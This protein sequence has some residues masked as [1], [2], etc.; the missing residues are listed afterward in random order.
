MP[1][2]LTTIAAILSSSIPQN[3][4]ILLWLNSLIPLLV[5]G[6]P[7]VT[8]SF[9]V[10]VAA[11]SIGYRVWSGR[12]ANFPFKKIPLRNFKILLLATLVPS[13][14]VLLGKIGVIIWIAVAKYDTN[15][16]NLNLLKWTAIDHPAACLVNDFIYIFLCVLSVC[17]AKPPMKTKTINEAGKKLQGPGLWARNIVMLFLFLL[18]GVWPNIFSL[19]YLTFF[20]I[21]IFVHNI[22][23]NLPRVHG[24]TWSIGTFL[25]VFVT[26]HTAFVLVMLGSPVA[27]TVT[28]NENGALTWGL[29]ENNRRALQILFSF[30]RDQ[31]ITWTRKIFAA[32]VLPGLFWTFL[33]ILYHKPDAETLR[34]NERGIMRDGRLAVYKPKPF[35]FWAS[36]SAIVLVEPSILT[37]P[38]LIAAL[39]SLYQDSTWRKFLWIGVRRPNSFLA[40]QVY[41][42]L[43]ICIQY[44]YN[45]G[46]HAGLWSIPETSGNFNTVMGLFLCTKNSFAVA[47]QLAC[48]MIWSLLLGGFRFDHM[49]WIL[50]CTWVRKLLLAF[51]FVLK[52][53]FILEYNIQLLALCFFGGAIFYPYLKPDKLQT[54]KYIGIVS[55]INFVLIAALMIAKNY[56][57][58]VWMVLHFISNIYVVAAYFIA[59]FDEGTLV[60][61]CDSHFLIT[62]RGDN[63]GDAPSLLDRFGIVF[64]SLT[65]VLICWSEKNLHDEYGEQRATSDKSILFDKLISQIRQPL[66]SPDRLSTQYDKAFS[67]FTRRLELISFTFRRILLLLT[68]ALTCWAVILPPV[69]V[70]SAF[71]LFST[72]FILNSIGIPLR[73]GEAQQKRTRV[74]R[75]TMHIHFFMLLLF[76]LLRF[77]FAMFLYELAY[78]SDVT[79]S[80][81]PSNDTSCV[82]RFATIGVL[83]TSSGYDNTITFKSGRGGF[84]TPSELGIDT[85]DATRFKTLILYVNAVVA[86]WLYRILYY[87]EHTNKQKMQIRSSV[88]DKDPSAS[89]TADDIGLGNALQ[90]ITENARSAS[91]SL[92]NVSRLAD[93]LQ[94]TPSKPSVA[95]EEA[96]L[97]LSTVLQAPHSR[98]ESVVQASVLQESV[99]QESLLHGSLPPDNLPPESLPPESLPPKSVARNDSSPVVTLEEQEQPSVE[100]EEEK[101]GFWSSIEIPM[102]LIEMRNLLVWH[103][104]A[105]L[106]FLIFLISVSIRTDCL[107]MLTL[108][109]AVTWMCIGRWWDK[110]AIVFIF[111]TIF[112]FCAQYVLRF[113]Y[114]DEKIG[115]NSD[116]AGRL[117]WLGVR[118]DP[119]QT[120][121][122]STA[123]FIPIVARN[124]SLVVVCV[125]QRSVQSEFGYDSATGTFMTARI[126]GFWSKWAVDIATGL[127]FFLCLVRLNCQA[128]IYALATVFW[129]PKRKTSPKILLISYA[130]VLWFGLCTQALGI[131]SH[132]LFET[133]GKSG[134]D[135]ALVLPSDWA[136]YVVEAF[137][138]LKGVEWQV[139]ITCRLEWRRWC[140]LPYS[141]KSGEL[142]KDSTETLSAFD[143]GWDFVVLLF[144]ASTLRLFSANAEASP[145]GKRWQRFRLF[146]VTNLPGLMSVTMFLNG[147]HYGLIGFCSLMC[148]FIYLYLSSRSKK[149][150][151]R[152][153]YWIHTFNFVVLLLRVCN[154]C[155]FVPCSSSVEDDQQRTFHYISTMICRDIVTERSEKTSWPGMLLQFL[156]LEKKVA[157]TYGLLFYNTM[158]GLIFFFAIWTTLSVLSLQNSELY[159]KHVEEGHYEL[160]KQMYPIR[161]RRYIEDF[162]TN[163]AL[164][165]E[166]RSNQKRVTMRK[167]RRVLAFVDRLLT[168]NTRAF[169]DDEEQN[170]VEQ[171]ALNQGYEEGA[172]RTVINYLDTRDRAVI[173]ELLQEIRLA[174]AGKVRSVDVFQHAEQLRRDLSDV[175]AS[176][177]ELSDTKNLTAA[178]CVVRGRFWKRC[179]IQKRPYEWIDEDGSDHVIEFRAQRDL[180]LLHTC[181]SSDQH[182]LTCDCVLSNGIKIIKGETLLELANLPLNIG[183]DGSLQLSF[184]LPGGLGIG[185]VVAALL[186]TETPETCTV[187][188]MRTRKVRGGY[189]LTT[190]ELM[191]ARK[192]YVTPDSVF[193]GLKVKIRNR[194]LPVLNHPYKGQTGQ[195]TKYD[196]VTQVCEVS[197][198][199]GFVYPYCIGAIRYDLVARMRS[200]DK[201]EVIEPES[202]EKSRTSMNTGAGFKGKHEAFK[203]ESLEMSRAT[204]KTGGRLDHEVLITPAHVKYC[205]KK[206]FKV[207]RTL[208]CIA[209]DKDVDAN[210]A[211]TLVIDDT[212][213]PGLVGVRW[214]SK[215]KANQCYRVG[216]PET[217]LKFSFDLLPE[218]VIA[219]DDVDEFVACS[220][221]PSL[222]KQRTRN[223]RSTMK[224]FSRMKAAQSLTAEKS[225]EE[226][227]VMQQLNDAV[228]KYFS[229]LIFDPMYI[230]T[231]VPRIP[232]VAAYE[233]LNHHRRNNNILQLL[234]KAIVSRYSQ[235]FVTAAAVA[236]FSAN[237]CVLDLLRLFVAIFMGY[238]FYPFPP[239]KLWKYLLIFHLLVFVLRYMVNLPIFCSLTTVRDYVEHNYQ[240]C[241]KLQDAGTSFVEFLGIYKTIGQGA[242][243]EKS[244]SS[245]YWTDIFNILATIFHIYILRTSGQWAFLERDRTAIIR[246]KGMSPASVEEDKDGGVSHLVSAAE[247]AGLTMTNSSL[248]GVQAFIELLT[249][250]K[251][252]TLHM[253]QRSKTVQL[254]NDTEV[255]KMFD[256]IDKRGIFLQSHFVDGLTIPKDAKLAPQYLGLKKNGIHYGLAFETVIITFS[257]APGDGTQ[258]LEDHGEQSPSFLNSSRG[259]MLTPISEEFGTPYHAAH[260]RT[261]GSHASAHNAASPTSLQISSP[262]MDMGRLATPHEMHLIT[263]TTCLSTRQCMAEETL[264]QKPINAGLRDAID[265]SPHSNIERMG[266]RLTSHTEMHLT[267]A[268]TRSF[269]EAPAEEELKVEC[270]G[271]R[272]SILKRVTSMFIVL[273][274]TDSD[275]EEEEED[276][277]PNKNMDDGG[278]KKNGDDGKDSKKKKPIFGEWW[279][280]P[281]W[282]QPG[283]DLY[284][285]SFVI[286]F[287]MFLFFLFF[288]SAILRSSSGNFY[289]SVRNDV[290][291]VWSVNILSIHVLL[292]VMDRIFYRKISSESSLTNYRMTN[293][294]WIPLMLKRILLLIM[295]LVVNCSFVYSQGFQEPGNTYYIGALT[296]HYFVYYAL[297]MTYITVNLMQSRDGLPVLDHK[298]AI[299]PPMAH[300]YYL[301][302]ISRLTFNVWVFLPFV[303][304]IRIVTDWTVVHTSL[305]LMMY[306][307]VEDAY[308]N[309]FRVMHYNSIRQM[310]FFAEQRGWIEKLGFGWVLLAAMLALIL[311][312][313][314]LF[315][316]WLSFGND[317]SGKINATL[318]IALYTENT[319]STTDDKGSAN[320]LQRYRVTTLPVFETPY[321]SETVFRDEDAKKRIKRLKQ[322]STISI[323][324]NKAQV[325]EFHFGSKSSIPWNFDQLMR[326]G[327]IEELT[328]QDNWAVSFE[329]LLEWSDEELYRRLLFY[330]P[331]KDVCTHYDLP[332]ANDCVGDEAVLNRQSI[333]NALQ[334]TASTIDLQFW[335]PKF[336]VIS[337]SQKPHPLNNNPETIEHILTNLTMRHGS[338][339][340]Q[341]WFLYT[342]DGHCA[343]S[344]ANEALCTSIPTC[345]WVSS[346]STTG[347]HCLGNYSVNVVR[348]AQA[349]SL[350]SGL[351]FSSIFV[352]G[353][354]IYAVA[355]FIKAFWSRTSFRIIYEELPNTQYLMDLIQGISLARS[356]GDLYNEFYL[357]RA[358]LLI[359]RSPQVLRELSEHHQTVFGLYRT[360]QEHKA[361]GEGNVVPNS[362]QENT[363]EA[364]GTY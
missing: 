233:P 118:L 70:Y 257:A 110:V 112:I 247:V 308:H 180:D 127:L 248:P 64:F 81:K 280:M 50:P 228:K 359:Y 190:P 253:Q 57:R 105:V 220:S 353:T 159:I 250:D 213:S 229:E 4:G 40:L 34:N 161:A 332:C 313:L 75:I 189:S 66:Q 95:P 136:T 234:Q 245:T 304:D 12:D 9:Q 177:L 104:S 32:T 296:W 203:P 88:V 333:L 269:N 278:N 209:W 273:Q 186:H 298:E 133:T 42:C 206:R 217:D 175:T 331:S 137:C 123:Q 91:E 109:V 98:Q 149:A 314:Y 240:A 319:A 263:P 19:G 37:L 214:D 218:D 222:T 287:L 157:T 92:Q 219:K 167:L 242:R 35:I 346:S 357:Y 179:L 63:G 205:M 84:I 119:G 183:E 22:K 20:M 267:I 348:E 170:M 54:P 212:K 45:L 106:F 343:M 10:I 139:E 201:H 93:P 292:I 262:T 338:D 339:S 200:K 291:D 8:S 151:F 345:A 134:L 202:L 349:S 89:P 122:Y 312:P 231:Q 310:Y 289:A 2:W 315:S 117:D 309:I 226:K 46:G 33:V 80:P 71:L 223:A 276:E 326:E 265:T 347:G 305:D 13:A 251:N 363:G 221:P 28:K 124:F 255:E 216:V 352:Y 85:D 300:N 246:L 344:A 236:S 238:T 7:T 334:G 215:K 301:D 239:V 360:P 270:T 193:V 82:T 316:D 261:S 111:A 168:S 191:K 128:C 256:V 145:E 47:L 362:A 154:Q 320:R 330:C 204:M 5:W 176:N 120:Q 194:A 94:T 241:D 268:S 279:I 284:T 114:F 116:L 322:E 324:T 185:W 143:M 142:I 224:R 181:W 60:K 163:R 69:D 249:E 99:L 90:S 27:V 160:E 355:K 125:I 103:S 196:P 188:W 192:R 277:L 264:E 290:F 166:R 281:T 266:T 86:W 207:Y 364:S 328:S 232:S 237:H 156:G 72:A 350:L 172:V 288:N 252:Q 318:K 340:A 61:I 195:V 56:R 178:S 230:G 59:K 17:L 76:V 306:Y 65:Q 73:E 141:Y 30:E 325:G 148:S 78:S 36:T 187:L 311:F 77:V 24:S 121:G 283:R 329:L 39:F 341:P 184:R 275:E 303:D 335:M 323:I 62:G 165:L 38:L 67:T 144:V 173:Q 197:W 87:V 55:I 297:W 49:R 41:G 130:F 274:G 259:S 294:R 354:I 146:Y 15:T 53:I 51:L 342:S 150:R 83:N 96:P 97:R 101:A 29:D 100:R 43:V 260:M 211:G 153:V 132:P 68:A 337:P 227:S 14:I 299:R 162:L 225:Q 48:V 174:H 356:S 129:S 351:G 302:L 235:A 115:N 113:R 126:S 23:K 258:T 131:M 208:D 31:P 79:K 182:M 26:L 286:S 293:E 358:L 199:D 25:R 44:V 164:E 155:P 11:L 138:N 282:V 271:P 321:Q 317:E 244:W 285:V 18:C 3:V 21:N 58:P 210:E 272:S 327:I 152:S 254:F 1:Q 361:F 16:L 243:E 74:A 171:L 108:I 140:T 135:A 102:W 198:P 147:L 307:K 169:G 52:R 107:N 295:M 158:D 336:F 6:R